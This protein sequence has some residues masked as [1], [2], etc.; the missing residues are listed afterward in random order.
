M[1]EE[2]LPEKLIKNV[3]S[4]P[5]KSDLSNNNGRTPDVKSPSQLMFRV[6]QMHKEELDQLLQKLQF[7]NM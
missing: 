7:E 6:E 1:D 5:K 2:N 4:L 3:N